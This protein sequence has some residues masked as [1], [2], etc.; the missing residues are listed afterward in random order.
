MSRIRIGHG[1]VCMPF[2]YNHPLRAAELGI[3]ALVLGFAGADE[4]M[5]MIQMGTIP[6]QVMLETIR[7]FGH[8]VI[9]HFR[10]QEPA[11]SSC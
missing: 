4:I 5:C 8:H 1:V 10:A 9:P 3:G 11:A 6:Q 2:G 7:Q